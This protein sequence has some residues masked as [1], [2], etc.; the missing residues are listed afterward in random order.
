MGTSGSTSDRPRA[1]RHPQFRRMWTADTISMLGS[2]VSGFAL[3][4]IAVTALGATTGQMGLLQALHMV[5]VLL[6]GLLAGVWVDRLNVQRL[7]I[8]LDLIAAAL[9][10]VVPVAYW[11][12]FLSLPML[13]ALELAFGFLSP[14]WYPALNR[15]LPQVV[16]KDLVVDAYSMVSASI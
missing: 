12:G 15:F 8:A 4:V 10:A 9:M 14:F 5:P 6:F 7:L 2:N 3:P 16:G 11:L 13:Y 1:W